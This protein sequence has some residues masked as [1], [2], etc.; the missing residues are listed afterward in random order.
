MR[1]GARTV[2]IGGVEHEVTT[3][4]TTVT[5]GDVVRLGCSALYVVGGGRKNSAVCQCPTCYR[6]A[7]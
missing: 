4:R 7:S 5:P 1:T 2:V 3:P 6:T